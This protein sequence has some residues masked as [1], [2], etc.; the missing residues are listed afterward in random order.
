MFAAGLGWRN[1]S[2]LAPSYDQGSEAQAVEAIRLLL[3]LGLDINATNEAG[4][5]PL[6]AAVGGRG[7]EAIVRLLLEHGA[8]PTVANARERTPL[9]IAEAGNSERIAALLRGALE[10]AAPARQ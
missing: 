2:P 5:T 1:G 9:A 8:D 4:D 3:E 10:S 7:A 6:L